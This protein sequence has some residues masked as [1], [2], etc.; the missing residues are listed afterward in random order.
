MKIAI[1]TL[2]RLAVAAFAVMLIINGCSTQKDTGMPVTTT[3]NKAKTLF[4]EAR[5]LMFRDK[6]KEAQP[7]LTSAMQLDSNFVMANIYYA[8]SGVS[9]AEMQKYVDAAYQCKD[10]VSEPE[11][12]Y[13]MAI[14]AY[15]KGNR[16]ENLNEMKAA[17]DLSPTDK[18][19]LFEMANMLAG[20]G[21]YD[22]ALEYIKRCVE[23]DTTFAYAVN[24]E[25]Y[26]LFRKG[27][28]EE[29]EALYKKSIQMDAG[30]S[31]FYNNYGQ[32]L[33]SKG[34]FNE[35]IEMHKKAIEI[36]PAYMSY[37]YLGHC[38]VANGQYAAAR[39]N[40]TKAF[41]VSV[42]PDQKSFC[43]SSVAYTHLY[44][45]NLP[46]ALTAFDKQ[47][48][49]DRQVGKMG[50]AIINA[51]EYKAFCCLVYND[52]KKAEEFNNEAKGMISKLDLT[53]TVRN[54]FMKD[55]LFWDAYLNLFNGKTAEA[56]KCLDQYIKSLS[57]QEK[58]DSDN[59]LIVLQ[60][61]IGYYQHNYKE[62]I[63]NLDKSEGQLGMYYDGLAY[64]KMKNVDKAKEVLSKIVENHLTSIEIALT[65]PL[66]KRKL[67][68]LS[69]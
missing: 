27:K 56:Q 19:L 5:A 17:I 36:E 9:N 49:F 20:Y 39:E 43:L 66:A 67:E 48:D 64:E 42:N 65:K 11:R 14:S 53:E 34:A 60:G 50:N 18:Y 40:Y 15:L 25:G 45:G 59:D 44:E 54:S 38:Y 58:K 21:Q 8:F 41:E 51:T 3:S 37:L 16:D 22:N 12:H 23:A 55:T 47:I 63:L 68:E 29:S 30:I 4:K 7:L 69:K 13:I 52:L 6:N 28:T 33:R 35:A 10:K 46:D 2:I 31:T 24:Y 57:D 62:A 32:L 1:K 61:M 26:I